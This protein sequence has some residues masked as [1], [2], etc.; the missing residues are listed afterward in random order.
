MNEKLDLEK[1][2]KGPV[3]RVRRIIRCHDYLGKPA[4]VTK[5]KGEGHLSHRIDNDMESAILRALETENYKGSIFSEES[6]VVAFGSDELFLVSDPYCNTML[7]FRGVRESAVS[8]Y[9]YDGANELLAGVI[10]DLQIY[11]QINVK[12]SA[13]R[14]ETLWD[15]GFREIC[16]P[17]ETTDL[18]EAMVVIPIFK[19]K[20]RNPSSSY[21]HL[22]ESVG[23][24]LTIGGAIVALR[25][26]QGELEA[27]VDPYVGQ[28]TYEALAYQLAERAG[29]FVTDGDGHQ[30]DWQKLVEDLR[31]GS[32]SRQTIVAASNQSL[33]SSIMDALER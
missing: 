9:E 10:A 2:I 8:L 12:V 14:P 29:C 11:R 6:K 23:K 21:G 20:R 15:D 3:D 24:L 13:G 17:S 32:V 18:S 31:V 16:R 25:L 30:I 26:C 28:P 22:M 19:L 27:F 33:H 7:T 1:I 5:D 4:Q